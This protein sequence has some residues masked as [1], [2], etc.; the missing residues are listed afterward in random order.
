MYANNPLI[1]AETIDGDAVD[2]IYI[3]LFIYV[4]IYLFIL[5][6]YIIYI[7][8]SSAMSSGHFPSDTWVYWRVNRFLSAASHTQKW[9]VIA[10]RG[11]VPCGY[12]QDGDHLDQ[13]FGGNVA[14]GPGCL[15]QGRDLVPGGYGVPRVDREKT[16]GIP[17]LLLVAGSFA[18]KSVRN[19]ELSVVIRFCLQN[20]ALACP[21]F[22]P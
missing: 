10:I 5:L 7:W 20:H 6:Y 22:F 18:S 21:A 14:C 1:I 16:V 17:E 3:Y 4:C 19:L 9:L 2:H 13:Q 15:C 11:A 12:L 8:R